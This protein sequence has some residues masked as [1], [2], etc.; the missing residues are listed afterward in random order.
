MK[1]RL[2]I[3]LLAAMALLPA[4]TALAA[5]PL[6]VIAGVTGGGHEPTTVYPATHD[7]ITGVHWSKWNAAEAVGAGSLRLLCGTMG[8]PSSGPQCAPK[9]VTVTYL[10][11]VLAGCKPGG[12]EVLTYSMAIVSGANASGGL[13]QVGPGNCQMSGPITG[14]DISPLGVHPATAAERQSLRPVDVTANASDSTDGLGEATVTDNEE[15][16]LLR[17]R[18]KTATLLV[19]HRANG[20]V[21]LDDLPQSGVP[22]AVPGN[23]YL[24]LDLAAYN[25]LPCVGP[26]P[27]KSNSP[28][29]APVGTP[30]VPSKPQPTGPTGGDTSCGDAQDPWVS[31]PI[32]ESKL[33]DLA[34]PSEDPA[35]G[36][37]PLALTIGPRFNFDVCA[38]ES[39]LSQET[40]F[41]AL[42]WNGASLD[43]LG[44]SWKD[45]NGNALGAVPRPYGGSLSL[46][47]D[48]SGI[49]V[50]DTNQTIDAPFAST[51]GP[52]YVGQIAVGKGKLDY[53]LTP[54]LEIG[55]RVFIPQAVE[56]LGGILVV[57]LPADVLTGGLDAPAVIGATEVSFDAET[58]ADITEGAQALSQYYNLAL[59]TGG[60]TQL[61]TEL[62]TNVTPHL[63]SQL[64]SYVASAIGHVVAAGGHVVVVVVSAAYNGGAKAVSGGWALVRSG[65]SDAWNELKRLNPFIRPRTHTPRGKNRRR[66]ATPAPFE[67]AR[68]ATL[69]ARPL[70]RVPRRLGFR[71]RTMTEPQAVADANALVAYQG[72]SAVDV[73]P[74]MTAGPLRPGSTLAVAAGQLTGPYALLELTG[75]GYR[76]KRLVTVSSGVAADSFRLPRRMRAGQWW[77]AVCSYTGFQQGQTAQLDALDFSVRAH[78]RHR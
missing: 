48:A 63:L 20:W 13:W 33:G 36:E 32:D 44:F 69:Q 42:R 4:G 21:T 7:E 8:T 11:P 77:V 24:A 65:A 26:G 57:S 6:P 29:P 45:A 3:I 5:K 28:T 10:W 55:G 41:S 71:N 23:V 27:S 35:P 47:L 9:N 38:G 37:F 72:V 62:L 56:Y 43:L 14:E 12:G 75:P 66:R 67:L 58:A 68:I 70:T 76:G 54:S 1:A 25:E 18:D 22:C 74:L 16:G 60:A 64:G 2:L 31:V 40:G 17:D 39:K 52:A 78:K 53:K 46:S 59:N 50:D 30:T 51:E 15:W 73:R 34:F 19:E 61:G 49:S